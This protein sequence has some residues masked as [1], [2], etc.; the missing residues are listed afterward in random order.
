MTNW[1]SSIKLRL[2]IWNA[3]VVMV[4]YAISAGGLY[5]FTRNGVEEQILDRLEAGY[6][7]VNDVLVYSGGDIYDVYHLGHNILF[8]ILKNGEE[9]YQT[10]KWEKAGLPTDL[11]LTEFDPYYTWVSPEKRYYKLRYGITI[12]Y[13]FTIVFAQEFTDFHDSIDGLAAKLSSGVLL[14]L[15]MAVLGGY[16]LAGRALL[17]IR[18]I[19]DKAAS[20]TASS[21]SERLP[22]VNPDDE[23]G[24]LAKVF[25]ELLARL[26]TSFELLKRFTSDAS[27]ELRTPLTSIKSAGEVALQN[28]NDDNIYREAIGSMLE[29]TDRLTNLADQLLTLARG[30][31]LKYQPEFAETDVS[32]LAKDVTA[33]LQV[34]AEEKGIE[35]K[36]D[37]NNPLIAKVNPIPLRQAVMNVVHNSIQYTP[38]N[39]KVEVRVF[40]VGEDTVRIEVSDSGPGIPEELREKVFERF[41]RVDK[42]RSGSTGGTGLGLAIAKWGVEAQGG[43]IEFCDKEGAGSLLRITIPGTK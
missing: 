37:G 10:E 31:S 38:E 11:N 8:K 3:V 1:K 27:H 40:A 28:A 20:I 19:T 5:F 35:V 6:N 39:G 14:V 21:L 41:Y 33:E 16:F 29:E 26:E 15:W 4:I 36:F 22:V 25:N 12:D 13:G 18:K 43:K 7:V 32:K 24:H 23:I 9:V 30:D 34:L 2:T 42:A 17:P